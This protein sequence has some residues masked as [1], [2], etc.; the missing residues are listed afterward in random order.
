MHS[1]LKDFFQ[2]P[3]VFLRYRLLKTCP[4]ILDKK[5]LQVLVDERS[6]MRA[7]SDFNKVQ[8]LSEKIHLLYNCITNGIDT[9]LF[10]K[11]HSV[12]PSILES[13]PEV[14]VRTLQEIENSEKPLSADERIHF[15]NN[16][17]KNLDRSR[18]PLF[19][20]ELQQKLCAAHLTNRTKNAV[21]NSVNAI[22]CCEAALE[23]YRRDLIPVEWAR[24]QSYLGI[25]WKNAP[26]T[27]DVNNAEQSIHHY[28]QALEGYSADTHPLNHA[29][30]L[31]NLA[32]AFSSRSLGDQ[33]ENLEKA[34][35]FYNRSLDVFSD[36]DF[37]VYRAKTHLNMSTVF[38]RRIR[39]E[40]TENLES[41]VAHL[42]QS[43]EVFTIQTF[44]NEWAMVQTNLGNTMLELGRQDSIR[45]SQTGIDRIE[46]A[47]H[48]YKEA[49]KIRTKDKTPSGWARVNANLATA[50]SERAIGSKNENIQA[51]LDYCRNALTV[52][53]MKTTP[54]EWANINKNL[55][56]AMVNMPDGTGLSNQNIALD[57]LKAALS[58]FT[59][60]HFP[61]QRLEILVA[62]SEI[63]MNQTDWNAA[64]PVFNEIRKID[65]ELS[66]LDITL[67]SKSR[68]VRITGMVYSRA[69][70]CLA[71]CGRITE[72]LEWLE[73]GKM[74]L[75]KD[76]MSYD[77]IVFDSLKKHHQDEYKQLISK[78]RQLTAEQ[79]SRIQNR[80]F[81]G[82][83][84]EMRKALS[85][86]KSLS[87]R[88]RQYEPSFLSSEVTFNHMTT[89]LPDSENTAFV[90]FNVTRYGSFSVILSGN[91]EQTV[92]HTVFADS[93]KYD[94][95]NAIAR[96]FLQL[97]TELN[98]YRQQEL[99]PI[100]QFQQFSKMQ[101]DRYTRWNKDLLSL[102]DNLSTNLMSETIRYLKKLNVKRLFLVTHKELNILPFH[103]AR[104]LDAPEK[105]Y[106]ADMFEINYLPAFS[107]VNNTGKPLK[108]SSEKSFLGISDSDPNLRW[109]R[110]EIETISSLF[111]NKH[112]LDGTHSLSDAINA[113]A[114]GYDILHFCCHAMFDTGDPY[115]S[116]LTF[117]NAD[118]HGITDSKPSGSGKSDS[119][120]KSGL[121]ETVWTLSDILRDL[122][123]S[124]TELVVLSSCESGIAETDLL[125]DEGIGLFTGFLLAGA[126]RILGSLWSVP[127]KSA[128]L[129][130]NE[131]YRNLVLKNMSPAQA[132]Q[133]AQKT[134]RNQPEH[135]EPMC[136]AAFRLVGL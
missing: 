135:S 73:T 29:V 107:L 62:V 129:I 13:I 87:D 125:P 7:F 59:F 91:P 136:W 118:G 1:L 37:P 47:I 43:L 111:K 130:M 66:K 124:G 9:T 58:V 109:I 113:A 35:Q 126:R 41:A 42:Q 82:I 28:L 134:L 70:W 49:L 14:Y 6:E 46:S 115:S 15:L 86:L 30:T 72:A 77:K 121:K 96:Q 74:Q 25:A 108:S 123:L 64:I 8:S 63:L 69:A 93:F 39:G 11:G 81:T 21:T 56:L 19:W 54:I 84:D 5:L 53:N 133:N 95:L 78:I 23:E 27:P 120:S 75:F 68:R 94:H 33:N 103:L 128:Y 18:Y 116:R 114:S 44:P 89:L 32:I 16:G 100:S 2:S 117:T 92:V 97:N 99:P 24:I 34:I 127:D 55:A 3:G 51:V 122:N 17:I 80:A 112:C 106:L 38:T 105:P 101:F 119:Y 71:K 98:D 102:M 79:Q 36:F 57:H 10:G 20:G 12:Q 131:F 90:I 4:E 67:S 83:A 110:T 65:N 52:F 88:I 26:A 85:D 45:N 31:M 22:R 76:R 40:R 60:D 61:R 50:Y 132:L 48:H 104:D